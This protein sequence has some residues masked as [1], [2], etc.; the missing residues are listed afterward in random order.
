ML[1]VRNLKGV[2]RV[3]Q[4]TF[5]DTYSKTAFAKL[6]IQPKHRLKQLTYSMTRDC[7]NLI[8]VQYCGRVDQH[9]YQLYLAI[10]DID[11][12]KTKA[13]SPQTNGICDQ[14]HPPGITLSTSSSSAYWQ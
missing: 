10:N 7:H 2:G 9:Y 1:Y 8:E 6:S 12:T 14:H 11:H 3:Y 5:I 13:M 4:Q